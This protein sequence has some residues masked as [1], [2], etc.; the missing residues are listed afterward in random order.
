ML[1]KWDLSPVRILR[2]ST[3]WFDSVKPAHWPERLSKS[4]ECSILTF[5]AAAYPVDCAMTCRKKSAIASDSMTTM[6]ATTKATTVQCVD[7]RLN[8]DDVL[9][10]CHAMPPATL[11]PQM[12]AGKRCTWMWPRFWQP[13]CTTHA[14]G[15]WQWTSELRKI[16]H[17]VEYPLSKEAW[18]KGA[19][20]LYDD[21]G[22]GDRHTTGA[23]FHAHKHE[24]LKAFEHVAVY[25]VHRETQSSLH[26]CGYSG[27]QQMN[28]VTCLS[29][30]K[31]LHVQ[32]T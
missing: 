12:P 18:V 8:H 28:G 1:S 11:R 9:L 21:D 26:R 14:I 7:D 32:P 2:Q 19:V 25:D 27:L 24:L 30:R 5:C 3:V 23:K 20:F 6:H 22:G 15:R 31:R 4:A 10:A 17:Q 13:A 29:I 16:V